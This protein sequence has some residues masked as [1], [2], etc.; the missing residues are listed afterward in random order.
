MLHVIFDIP[1]RPPALIA[2][3]SIALVSRPGE[4]ARSCHGD[5]AFP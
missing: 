4:N 2:C 5:F 1:A 3:R